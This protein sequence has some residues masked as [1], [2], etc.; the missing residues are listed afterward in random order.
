MIQFKDSFHSH[1]IYLND[2]E[3][4]TLVCIADLTFAY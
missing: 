1:S 2:Y 3:G 4:F